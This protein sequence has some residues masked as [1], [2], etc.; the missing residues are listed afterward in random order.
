MSHMFLMDKILSSCFCLIDNDSDTQESCL[1]F[2]PPFSLCNC[3]HSRMVHLCFWVLLLSLLLSLSQAQVSTESDSQPPVDDGFEL[4][5]FQSKEQYRLDVFVE[6]LCP[7]SKLAFSTLKSVA[8][9][10]R[11]I[12]I[13][14]HLFSLPYFLHSFT[15]LQ[16]AYIVNSVNSRSKMFRTL[17][18]VDLMFDNQ[19][20]FWNSATERST[21]GDVISLLTEF[22]S[23]KA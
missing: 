10:T 13:Q 8:A 18:W 4:T 6:M 11:G 17:D 7:D 1:L 19:E 3:N 21:R 20:E 16:S 22:A 14:V 2:L 23:V 15:V 5:S 12:Q 9:T